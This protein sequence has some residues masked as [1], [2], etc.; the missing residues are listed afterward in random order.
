MENITGM[1]NEEFQ[2]LRKQ[3]EE[4]YGT[5][6]NHSNHLLYQPNCPDCWAENL[7]IKETPIKTPYE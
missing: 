5:Q 7:T 1:S 3:A 6:V 2:E 4:I